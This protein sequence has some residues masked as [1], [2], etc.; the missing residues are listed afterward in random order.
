LAYQICLKRGEVQ[1]WSIEKIEEIIREKLTH[2]E[3]AYQQKT[4]NKYISKNMAENLEHLLFACPQCC[5]FNALVSE[6]DR[7]I[8]HKC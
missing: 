7:L 2:D 4:R 6:G 1:K 8:C 3:V 5:S